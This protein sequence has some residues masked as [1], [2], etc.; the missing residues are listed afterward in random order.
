LYEPNVVIV[1]VTPVSEPA[2]EL[3]PEAVTPVIVSVKS[4]AAFVPPLLLTTCL[5]TVRVAVPAAGGAGAA[6]AWQGPSLS[7]C[8]R[9]AL[10]AGSA[11]V[12]VKR[13]LAHKDLRFAVRSSLD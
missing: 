9:C 7:P 3:T 4:P 2:N 5:I 8:F 12:I 10:T 11:T 13:G 1:F 6:P